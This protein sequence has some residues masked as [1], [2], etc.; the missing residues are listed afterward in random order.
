MSLTKP[1]QDAPHATIFATAFP[2]SGKERQWEQTV[3]DL[4]RASNTF[5]GHQGSTLLKPDPN[6]TRNYRVL[7]KFDTDQNMW[8]WY[9]SDQ[10][11]E[12]VSRLKQFE[13]QPAEIQHLTGFETWFA[14]PRQSVAQTPPKYKMAIVVWIAVY[15]AVLPLVGFLKPKMA[16]L[17]TMLGSAVVAAA[18]V[19]MMTWIVLPC[20]TWV[21]KGWLYPKPAAT[22]RIES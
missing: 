15:G 1:N 21:F 13:A 19:A 2:A 9:E 17:P 11:H 6:T 3:G 7:T 16:H 14:T 4:I 22:R 5:P 18:S 8:R 20:L 10:R 12:I